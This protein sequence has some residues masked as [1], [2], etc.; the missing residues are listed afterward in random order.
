MTNRI[1][2]PRFVV[3]SGT[4][5]MTEWAG[6]ADVTGTSSVAAA[7][8]VLDQS[9]TQA[10][11]EAVTP[12]TLVRTIG[13]LYVRSD[14]TATTENAFGAMG[15]AV[16]KENARAAGAASLPG[17]ITNEDDDVWFL[18]QFFNAGIVVG[19]EVGFRGSS[20]WYEYQFDSKAQRKVVSGDAV[21][22]MLENASGT[23]G[24]VYIL[25]WRMLFKL[26]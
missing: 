17:P 5:R 7:A 12:A 10:V 15:A 21:V 23:A 9:L 26:H 8:K 18:Y 14:Q 16:V 22:F 4:R 11:L 13:S 20:V 2:S 3:R 6:S 24:F 25:K 19:S 1:R